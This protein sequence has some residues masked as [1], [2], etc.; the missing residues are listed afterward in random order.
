MTS[1]NTFLLPDQMSEIYFYKNTLSS[2]KRYSRFQLIFIAFIFASFFHLLWCI[3]FWEYTCEFYT[4]HGLIITSIYY[5]ELNWYVV[6]FSKNEII[7]SS[8]VYYE[9]S[10]KSISYF[11]AHPV[12]W[13]D[14][15]GSFVMPLD[16]D[17]ITTP[18]YFSQQKQNFTKWMV[19]TKKNL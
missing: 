9:C 4:S 13:N 5:K 2:R 18:F 1:N 16:L 15:Y 14:T 17:I 10:I 7:N 8:C 6:G 19:T 12:R 3:S 11:S